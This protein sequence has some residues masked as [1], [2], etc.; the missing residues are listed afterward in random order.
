MSVAPMAFSHAITATG[1]ADSG[2]RS[3]PARM[4]GAMN[5]STVGPTAHVTTSASATAR[6]AASGSALES[7]PVKPVTV[8][9]AASA[10][11]SRTSYASAARSIAMSSA[12]TSTNVTS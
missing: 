1:A 9:T 6:A 12:L 4:T 8:W 7:M 5:R 10:P 2:R 11:T 3:S